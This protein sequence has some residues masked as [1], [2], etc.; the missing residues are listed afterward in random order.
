V[1]PH[2]PGTRPAVDVVVVGQLARDLLLRVDEV[3]PHGSA[4]DVRER[5]ETLGGK[6][7]NCAVGLAQ[8]GVP[9]GLVAVA[10]SDATGDRLL[11]RAEA[12]G[13]DVEHVVRRA[14]TP[15]GLIV[16]ILDPAHGWR[17]LQ[18]LPGPTLLTADDV[19]GA[20]A[21][22]RAARAV[23]L[24]AQQ[25]AAALTACARHARDGSALVV[26]DGAPDP[27]A[28]TELLECADV[29]RADPAETD[30]LVDGELGRLCVEDVGAM[31]AAARHLLAHGP[32]VV[33]VGVEGAGN[34]AVWEDGELFV[35]FGDVEV[36]DTTGGGDSL[37]AGL[38]AA[39]LDGAD[40]A[41]AVRRAVEAAG[42][43]VARAG[44]RPALD[45]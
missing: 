42:S 41:S 29:V 8:L 12:D 10:G 45:G 36:V 39:L 20:A 31:T 27:A 2:V 43:T 25:P 38:T 4:T 44:G 28:R 32:R 6:G 19:A 14:G 33:V 34:V 21:D 22:L 13:V 40:P 5:R 16:E 24:Q 18:H 9:V 35:P 7:A 1:N 11:A 26:L 3:P 17:Y 30:E 23:V 37:T 15:T